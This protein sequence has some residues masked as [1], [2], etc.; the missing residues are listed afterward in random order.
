L[1]L[2]AFSGKPVIVLS[3]RQSMNEKGALADDANE[4]RKDIA[5]LYPG[6]VQIWVDSSHGIP[7]EKPEAVIAAIRQILPG[8]KLN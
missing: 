3:A 2:P 7:L 4:K 5:R 8:K 6:S 1:T